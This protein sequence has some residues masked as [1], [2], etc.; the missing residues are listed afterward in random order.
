MKN[1][2]VML[3]KN[4]SSVLK[5]E[6]LL[7]GNSIKFKLIPVPRAISSECGMCLQYDISDELNII[8]II[9]DEIE[10]EEIRSL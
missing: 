4:V 9:Q 7:K 2:R 3:F 10:F 5:V 8:E 1:Y 6:K